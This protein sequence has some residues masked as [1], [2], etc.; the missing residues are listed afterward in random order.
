MAQ[1]ITVHIKDMVADA[2]SQIN[3]VD[4]DEA[5][6]LI[7]DP[8]TIIIDIRDI[9][10]RQREGFIEGAIHVPRGMLEFWIDPDSPYHK[11]L[12]TE[13]KHFIFHCASGWRS[14]LATKTAGDMG[15]K[16]VSHIKGGF[17]A[18]V[19]VGGLVKKDDK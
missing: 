7:G 11:P 6:S 10:E 2:R 17:K 13:D 4:A 14:A 5:I 15:L 3:E 19:D 18:W 12:F 9:R 8:N 1:N 16:P